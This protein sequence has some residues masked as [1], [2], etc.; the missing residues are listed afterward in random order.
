VRACDVGRP[1]SARPCPSTQRKNASGADPPAAHHYMPP[2]RARVRGRRPGPRPSWTARGQ[3]RSSVGPE[4]GNN[5][6]GLS[7]PDPRAGTTRQV[8]PIAVSRGRR[9]PVGPLGLSRREASLCEPTRGSSASLTNVCVAHP[10]VEARPGPLAPQNKAAPAGPSQ[11][12][13]SRSPHSLPREVGCTRENT[14]DPTMPVHGT[15][16]DARTDDRAIATIIG[17]RP[18]NAISRHT[19]V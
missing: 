1:L 8:S 4:G 15:A 9:P 7:P 5:A 19:C 10:R 18:S 2:M 17:V 11:G 6:T 12:N 13:W 3:T 16:H 14:P